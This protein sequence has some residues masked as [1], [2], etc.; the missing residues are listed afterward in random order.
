M[1]A[2]YVG[3]RQDQV[4]WKRVDFRV[5]LEPSKQKIKH[6]GLL[7]NTASDDSSSRAF[8]QHPHITLYPATPWEA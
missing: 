8:S 7:G 2:G 5:P 6:V 4:K 3:R 1:F